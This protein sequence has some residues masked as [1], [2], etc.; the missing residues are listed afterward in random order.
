[1][2]MGFGFLSMLF[3]IALPIVGII[4]LIVWLNK[5]NQQGNPFS[6]NPPLRK[7]GADQ[8]YGNEA[9]LFPLR[10]RATSELDSLST[11]RSTYRFV[12]SFSILIEVF[13]LTLSSLYTAKL[14]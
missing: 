14:N 11:M 10:G 13:N 8:R 7:T 2:M 1:M 9:L 3:V 12:K 4:A 6:T 5:I